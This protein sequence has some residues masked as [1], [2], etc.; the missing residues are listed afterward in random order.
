MTGYVES[1]TDPS[2]AG[3]ILTFTYPLI[4]N[5]GV[6]DAKFWESNKIHAKGVIVSECAPFESHYRKENSLAAWLES[7]GVPLLTGVDTRA[8]TKELRIHGTI[9]GVICK[10]TIKPKEFIDYNKSGLL[11]EVSI[12]RP[13][14]FGK[15]KRIIAIDC[16]MKENIM[17]SLLQ[18]PLEVKRVPYDYDFTN[19]EY[20]GVFISNGPGDPAVCTKTIAILKKALKNDQKPIF[21]NLLGS[22]TSRTC[23]WRKDL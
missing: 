4:G 5:Y 17:R 2:Y 7:Q 1:L 19:E 6:P 3:Q 20:D 22:S 12:T 11:K 16:G 23:N 13:E 8:L 10:R 14:S 9:P 21:W 18:F 15:G